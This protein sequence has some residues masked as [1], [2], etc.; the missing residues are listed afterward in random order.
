MEV[1]TR[2]LVLLSL[3][4]CY[5]PDLRDCTVTC[6]SSDDC[7]GAQICG[8]D[9]FCALPAIAGTCARQQVPDAGG[10]APDD[11]PARDAG[12]TPI[13]AHVTPVDAAMPD[14][15]PLATLHLKVM[16]HGQLVAGTHTCTM[17]CMFQVP[18]VPIDVIAVGTGDQVLDKWSEGPCMG[19]HAATCTVT[20]PIT[21]AAKFHKDDEH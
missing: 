7:A 15:P 21:V 6:A 20:A 12:D 5:T 2:A 18:A 4:A 14:A 16:G 8:G 3:T 9:H 1:L 11:G 17:D 10:A 13:D 19:S